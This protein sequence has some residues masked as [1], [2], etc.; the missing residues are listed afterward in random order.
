MHFDKN[1]VNLTGTVVS[2]V[3]DAFENL[4]VKFKRFYI[5]TARHSGVKDTLLVVSKENT[6]PEGITVGS[7]VTI[8]GEFRIYAHSFDFID[9]KN[10]YVVYALSCVESDSDVDVNEVELIG[11]PCKVKPIR[12]TNSGR[13][14]RE[15]VIAVNK[16]FLSH[17]GKEHSKAYYINCLS[18]A[19][20]LYF[21]DKV[22]PTDL[23]RI[24]GR[25]QSRDFKKAGDSKVQTAYEVSISAVDR[26]TEDE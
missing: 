4:G 24:K 22:V 7:R 13:S 20:S 5:E 1:E 23:I 21:F 2:E 12:G 25:L 6:L 14:L 19:N 16:Y 10:A 11:Y 3:C 17:D 8:N 26:F 15:V 18:W 9:T